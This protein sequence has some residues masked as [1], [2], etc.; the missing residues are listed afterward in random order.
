MTLPFLDPALL[1]W[2]GGAPLRIAA[3]TLPLGLE[4]LSFVGLAAPRGGQLPVYSAQA[5][6]I[7]RF[8]RIG[9]RSNLP[10]SALLARGAK[11]EARVDIPRHEWQ[12]DLD[13]T[14]RRVEGILRRPPPAVVEPTL[15]AA[16]TA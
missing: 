4:R 13:R 3:M 6:L 7:A 12:R 16:T 15:S 14:T 9:E 8:L 10:L 11:P 5:R 1:E 2:A